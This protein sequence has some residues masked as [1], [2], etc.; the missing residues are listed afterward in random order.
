MR[1][2]RCAPGFLEGIFRMSAAPRINCQDLSKRYPVGMLDALM[3]VTAGRMLAARARMTTAKGGPPAVDGVNLFIG[4]GERVGIIGRNGAGKSTLL[5]MLAGLIE[6]SGGTLDLTGQ[7]TAVLTLGAG[8][9][10]ECTGRKNIY[11]DGELRGKTHADIDRVIGEIIE[12]TDIGAYID[13]PLRTYSTG[14]KARLAFAMLIHI[15]PEILLIDEALSVGDI[16]FAAKASSK[17]REVC[18]RGK[19]VVVVSHSMQSIVELC[20]RCIWMESGRIRMEGNPADVTTA[21]MESVR[22]QEEA[23]L[24]DRFGA[25]VQ[26]QSCRRGFEILSLTAHTSRGGPSRAILTAGEDLILRIDLEAGGPLTD[27]DVVLR[28]RRLDGTAVSENRLSSQSGAGALSAAR[29]IEC[30]VEMRPLLLGAGAYQLLAE[31]TD[32]NETVASRSAVIEVQTPM[33]VTGG[34]PSLYYPCFVNTTTAAA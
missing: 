7:V 9:R 19:I 31:L 16:A 2:P 32:G 24:L 22:R 15:E 33:P 34:R 18:N 14:M 6:P 4:A 25:H 10:E 12:F 30:E 28:I 20:N 11:I 8:L 21:Y 26:A 29:R 23:S 13:Y 3:T 17:I 27:P 5:G 1:V